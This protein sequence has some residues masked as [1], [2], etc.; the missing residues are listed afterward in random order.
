MN[1]QI[2]DT[3]ES[4]CH[5][6]ANEI[7]SDLE[8]NPRQLLCIAAG[9]TSL[10]VFEG[11]VKA[12]REGRADFSRA[13][14]VAMDEWLNMSADTTESCGY[15]LREHFLKHVNYAPENVRLWNGT[16]DDPQKECCAVEAFIG[17]KSIN[18]T[19]DYLVLGS[20]MNGHLA[21]NEPG[22]SFDSRAHVTALDPVTQKVGQKYFSSSASLTGGI[23]LGIAN[24][25]SAARTVLMVNGAAKAEI[26]AR[27]LSAAS[28]DEQLPASALLGF[29]NASLYCDRA[30]F[31][32]RK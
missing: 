1:T 25:R 9:H 30:A 3:Y 20:G 16:A 18:H 4:M 26:L 28:P 29:E 23:T 7:I 14:F 5:Y 13:S 12:Y 17:Q 8:K 31:P 22:T 15:F 2:F 19:I 11:L 21:L 24:F 32:G 6:V 10:G 27:I